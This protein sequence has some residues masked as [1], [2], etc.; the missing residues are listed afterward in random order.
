[1]KFLTALSGTNDLREEGSRHQV[2]EIIVHEA[3]D[4]DNWYIND[5]AV[6]RVETPFVFDANTAPVVLPA[7]SQ[8]SA[9]GAKGTLVGWGLSIV[10]FFYFII[11]IFISIGFELAWD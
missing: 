1:M 4:P 3:Y 6:V 8:H 11:S 9:P 10:I 2:V 7:Q 5:I